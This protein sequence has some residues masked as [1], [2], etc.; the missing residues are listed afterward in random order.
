MLSL[1]RSRIIVN[2]YNIWLPLQGTDLL[3]DDDGQRCG[4]IE[5]TTKI[6]IACKIITMNTYAAHRYDWPFPIRKR[7]TRSVYST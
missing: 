7:E 2:L 3:Y 4:Q 1:K 6:N 5:S